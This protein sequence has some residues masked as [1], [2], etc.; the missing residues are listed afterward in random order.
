MGWAW[1]RPHT[2]LPLPQCDLVLTTALKV[3]LFP[4][5]RLETEDSGACEMPGLGW[6]PGHVWH[7]PLGP[8]V[9]LCQGPSW[10]ELPL[11]LRQHPPHTPP[12]LAPATL[13]AQEALWDPGTSWLVTPCSSLEHRPRSPERLGYRVGGGVLRE[14]LGLLMCP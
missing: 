7:R 2:R 8:R 5:Y 6:S 13:G 11:G 1:G 3:A 4:L 12:G 10:P 9:G 14:A